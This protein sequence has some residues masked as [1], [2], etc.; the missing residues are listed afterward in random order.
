MVITRILNKYAHQYLNE[1]L[2]LLKLW[3]FFRRN[4]ASC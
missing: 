1:R 3:P 4:K 2:P